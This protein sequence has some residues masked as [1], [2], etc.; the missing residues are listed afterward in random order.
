MTPEPLGPLTGLDRRTR[1]KIKSVVAKWV[2]ERGVAGL[3]VAV[4]LPGG[5][6]WTSVAGQA[7]FSPPRRIEDDTIFAVASVTKTFTAA[8]ILRLVEEGKLS[9][10]ETF[11]TYAPGA[12]RG[13][14]VTI[15]QLLSH[16]SGIYNY[17]ENPRYLEVFKDREHR[18]TYEEIIDLVKDGYCKPGACY[19][20]S[21]TNFVIL[22]K[23]AEVA[24][25]APLHKQ[26]Q[27]QFFKPLGMNDT[28]YQPDD[29]TPLDAAHGHWP[30]STGGHID[31]T[32][33]ARVIPFMAAAS[34]ASS[35]GAIASTARDLAT[36]ARALYGGD[37]LTRESLREM[38]TFLPQG[39]YGL[40]TDVAS[41]GG[42]RAVGHR[43]GL[44]G[45]ESSMWYFPREDVSIVLLSNQGNWF[46]D[47]PFD[48]IA[49]AVFRGR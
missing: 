3:S 32:R 42:K 35:A 44:R 26:F 13:R 45:Y 6:T 41:F 4:G 40:G 39:T 46:T 10:D 1:K 28:I 12:P 25:G 34:V 9:L 47:V 22:G 31:H 33:T 18:W 7:Q 20:Y 29:P 27:Q 21:N 36:W 24:G 48:R 15:R 49:E 23:I 5:E 14:S 43:G 37:V 19:H 11:G 16:T 8:L 30:R 38:T 2:H 17:F